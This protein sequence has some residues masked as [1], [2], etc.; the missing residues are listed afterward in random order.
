V[1]NSFEWPNFYGYYFLLCLKKMGLSAAVQR[2][3]AV[4]RPLA[5]AL[6]GCASCGRTNAGLP[7]GLRQP[8]G[9]NAT[10]GQGAGGTTAR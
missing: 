4:A 10:M 6:R 7:A 3:A 5:A 2:P 8:F 1:G 9:H